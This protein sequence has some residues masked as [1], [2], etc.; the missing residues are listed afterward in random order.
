MREVEIKFHLLAAIDWA[1]R[2]GSTIERSCQILGL[3]R[4]RYYRWK[5]DRPID[6]IR[7]EDLRDHR[8]GPAPG[9]G[10]HRLLEVE[11]E[12]IKQAAREDKYQDLHHRKLCHQI[13]RDNVAH[14]SESSVYRVLKAEN[15]MGPMAPV[16]KKRLRPETEATRP[17][18][19]WGWDISYLKVKD[20]FMYLI[21]I[22]DYYSRKIVGH[23]LSYS[24]TVEDMKRVWDR[25]LILEGL[26][27]PF[28]QPMNLTAR[29]DNGPQMKAKSI[30]QFFRDLGIVQEFTR[31]STPTDNAITER[32]YKTIK[33]EKLY[34]E[35]LED[36]PMAISLVDEFV[37]YYNE[38][39]LHQGIEFVT[40]QER[41]TGKDV[42]ILA[43]RKEALEQARQM[44][45]QA[46]RQL[47]GLNPVQA[48]A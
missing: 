26:L 18:Q 13:G 12:R 48:R 1:L 44:R 33:Y 42:Q 7:I 28:G 4:S 37:L 36:L 35:D 17:N 24:Q 20:L 21:A 39:R 22:I 30:R 32:W 47:L 45:L 15:L 9:A 38:E 34:R 41:H 23:E 43:R 10:V 27:D 40:P 5:E 46:N 25:A 2:Q 16:G 3:E 11:K 31:C 8:P 6:Q 14:I 29:S 19:L